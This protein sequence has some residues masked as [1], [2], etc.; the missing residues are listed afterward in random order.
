MTQTQTTSESSR[1]PVDIEGQMIVVAGLRVFFVEPLFS[2]RQPNLAKFS[3]L[4]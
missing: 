3:M 4:R 1:T 2:E